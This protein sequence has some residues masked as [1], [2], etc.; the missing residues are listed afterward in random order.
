L[1]S[2]NEPNK[3]SEHRHSHLDKARLYSY[4][5]QVEFATAGEHKNILYVGKGTGIAPYILS[6]CPGD[7]EV[8]TL[9]I[10]AELKPDILGSVLDI[11]MAD[12]AVD[13][14]MCCQVLEHLPFAQFLPALREMRRVTR[15]RLI[16]SL[17]DKRLYFSIRL[18][19]PL[20]RLSLPVSLPRPDT[21]FR[22]CPQWKFR[23]A[24]HFWE[25]GYKGS[26]LGTLKKH[27][28]R[29]GWKI[30]KIKRV[31]DLSWHTFFDLYPT[32]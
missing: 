25:I 9:D 22:P 2:E 30:N 7:P 23:E 13:V 29:A 12:R 3:K 19:A 28:R 1:H 20:I 8:I 16:M 18:K 17:P 21:M 31:Y 15:K 5:Y 26:S 32:D 10:D 11:P 24:G 27:L 14:T 6:R 4:I